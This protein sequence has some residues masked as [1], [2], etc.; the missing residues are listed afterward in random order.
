MLATNHIKLKN[1]R[2][3]ACAMHMWQHSSTGGYAENRRRRDRRGVS[4]AMGSRRCKQRH[5][6]G[7]RGGRESSSG[8]SSCTHCHAFQHC[9]W[10]PPHL[11]SQTWCL[12]LTPPSPTLTGRQL[13]SFIPSYYSDNICMG[14]VVLSCTLEDLPSVAPP[15]M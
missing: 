8:T 7:L 15:F 13:T 3:E 12:L 9:V 4:W 10:A 6:L 11:K 14:T 1:R 2:Y 5:V